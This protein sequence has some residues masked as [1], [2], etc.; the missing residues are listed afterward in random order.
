[1]IKLNIRFLI[2]LLGAFAMA[3]SL[4][5]EPYYKILYLL[6]AIFTLGILFTVINIISLS[7]TPYIEER[8][9]YTGNTELLE[10]KIKNKGFFFIPY[11]VIKIPLLASFFKDYSGEIFS[12][13]PREEVIL[14]YNLE[15]KV[16]GEYSFEKVSIITRD[17]FGI[18]DIRKRKALN[19]T[20]KVYPRERN[21]RGKALMDGDTFFKFKRTKN[22]YDDQFS[23]RDLR[24]YQEGDN[25]KRINWKVSAKKNELFVKNYES[26]SGE[27]ISVFLDMNKSNYA[28]DMEGIKEE[29][30]VD[31]T[32]SLLNFFLGRG[33]KSSIYLNKK[34]DRKFILTESRDIQKLI[35][36]LITERSDGIRAVESF[37]Q[38]ASYGINKKSAIAIVMYKATEGLCK[39]LIALKDRGFKPMLFVL[40]EDRT[41][42]TYKQRLKGFSIPSY[43]INE[44]LEGFEI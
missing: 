43:S 3:Y 26:T 30:M 9:Y 17:L 8:K 33:I 31:F 42:L 32:L 34:D 36:Y 28:L 5:G 19:G 20:L 12:L 22:S 14:K 39:E 1:M 15:L 38:E 4:G 35:E 37:I 11:V 27:E 18:V 44:L 24:K 41:Y 23:S 25:L 13:K 10:V 7:V 6:L 21:I 16:R 2:F 29:L 40:E